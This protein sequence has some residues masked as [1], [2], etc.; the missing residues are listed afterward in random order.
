MSNSFTV[1]LTKFAKLTSLT[2]GRHP[3]YV[4]AGMSVLNALKLLKQ[5]LV[6]TSLAANRFKLKI[7]V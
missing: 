1:L 7:Y 3:S 4:S 2:A 6:I 5:S